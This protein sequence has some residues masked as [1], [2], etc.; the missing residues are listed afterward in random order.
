MKTLTPEQSQRLDMLLVQPSADLIELIREL[1]CAET[2]T[3]VEAAA[4]RMQLHLARNVNQ[5]RSL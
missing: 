4:L 1:Y 2:A 5:E 3:E